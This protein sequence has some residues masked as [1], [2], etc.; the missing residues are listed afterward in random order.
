MFGVL[1]WKLPDFIYYRADSSC[2][3]F[4]LLLVPKQLWPSSILTVIVADLMTLRLYL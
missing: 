3:F 1:R 4:S 2:I